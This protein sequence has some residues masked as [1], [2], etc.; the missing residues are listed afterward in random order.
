MNTIATKRGV[1]GQPATSRA[2]RVPD[3]DPGP[4]TPEHIRARAYE[5]F[6]ERGGAQGDAVADWL[7]AEKEL[8]D[9][10][11]GIRADAQGL[12][13]VRSPRACD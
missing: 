7:R 5:V 2:A 8:N 11:T 1:P 10:L 9:A 12:L 13:R 4:V 6:Q 3:K